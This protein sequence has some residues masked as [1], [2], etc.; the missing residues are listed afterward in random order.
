MRD[1]WNSTFLAENKKL[2]P[3]KRR[4]GVISRLIVLSWRDGG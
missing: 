3:P 1:F 2:L 4:V